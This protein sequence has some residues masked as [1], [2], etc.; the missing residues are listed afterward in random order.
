MVLVQ[1]GFVVLHHLF[2]SLSRQQAPSL[3]HLQR[4]AATSLV[5]AAPVEAELAAEALLKPPSPL[6]RHATSLFARPR[7]CVH[8]AN[9]AFTDASTSSN[10]DVPSPPGVAMPHDF[11]LHG[12]PTHCTRTLCGSGCGVG[13]TVM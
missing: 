11:E 9:V 3:L 10:G 8:R 12:H 2:A 4:A 7:R 5:S 6:L 1:R 13:A